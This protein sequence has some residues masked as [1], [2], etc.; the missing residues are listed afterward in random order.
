MR[1]YIANIHNATGEY[2]LDTSILVYATP[3][4]L[5]DKLRDIA[6]N[7][8]GGNEE[9][10]DDYWNNGDMITYINSSKEISETTFNELR[11]FLAVL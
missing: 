2:E 5:D 1:Y 6:A 3:E 8:Y 4:T 9:E 7:W 11:G 10:G